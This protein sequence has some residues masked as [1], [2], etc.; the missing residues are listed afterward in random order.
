M[1]STPMDT[2]GVVRISR[3]V[4]APAQAVWDILA[5]GWFFPMWVVGAARMRSVDHGWP[6]VGTRLHHSVGNWP[7]LLDDRTEVLEVRPPE[8]MRLKTHGWPAGAAEVVLEVEDLG[9]RSRIHILEDAVE[10]PGSLVPKPVRQLAI[11][12]RNRETLRRLA[13]IAEGRAEGR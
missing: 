2:D 7:F 3:D 11:G 4:D 5:D 1:S 13:L 8:L 12:P 10:G 6:E 9:E